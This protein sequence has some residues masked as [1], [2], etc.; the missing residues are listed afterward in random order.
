MRH[1]VAPLVIAALLSLCSWQLLERRAVVTLDLESGKRNIVKLYWSTDDAPYGE[2]RMTTLVVGPGV[3]THQCRIGDLATIRRLRIDP[4]ER[5]HDWV[6]LKRLTLRQ[7]GFSEQQL[8]GTEELSRLVPL[9]GLAELES[10]EEGLWL[11][12]EGHD[13]RLEWRLPPMERH[14]GL[15]G[16][17]VRTACIFAAVLL[18]ARVT[19][20]TELGRHGWVP[21][22]LS[23]TLV[24]VSAMALLS[25]ENAHPDEAVHVEAARYF[26]HHWLP[27][28]IDDP[29]LRHTFSHYGFSRVFS[30]EIY[31]WVAGRYLQLVEPLQLPSYLAL[32]GLNVLLWAVMVLGVLAVPPARPLGVPLLI[33]PQICYVFS[34]CNS[35]A[36]ALT[37]SMIVAWQIAVPG[38]MFSRF[39]AGEDAGYWRR[40]L[41]LGSL[42]GLL[43]LAKKNYYFFLLF[44]PCFLA[45]VS[46]RQ[47]LVPWR[48]LWQRGLALAAVGALLFGL[49]RGSE[50]A[51]NGWD[52]SAKLYRAR[53]ETASPL[54]NP[55]SPRAAQHPHLG[56][57]D[58]GVGLQVL[59]DK[60]RW[61]EKTF[62][63]SFGVYGYTSVSASFAYY[64]L[65]RYLGLGLLGLLV[66]SVLLRGGWPGIIQ[67][68]LAGLV[69]GGL[70]TAALYI[71]WTHDFQA[72]GRY[73]L[74]LVPV[75]AMMYVRL[76]PVLPVALFQTLV[77][78]LYCVSLYSFVFVAIPGIL[79]RYGI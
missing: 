29:A 51:V 22:L 44:I 17:L 52:R 7:V 74:P 32:R 35:D 48:R 64:D 47:D 71:A 37:V 45:G 46:F 60:E 75:L 68:G 39:F 76:Y 13:A 42:V 18:L 28:E 50:Y 66:L 72:Q 59:L 40:C 3:S 53:V 23:M 9:G 27:P 69:A 12:S 41:L 11:A 61:G 78:L 62:R 77:L 2:E 65:V 26:Q 31:Y 63:S 58:R 43:L 54:F 73:L 36:M 49:V 25:Q 1:M 8:A 34:Y 6:M 4:T 20:G 14:G 19:H 57:R 16:T 15:P 56:M 67:L 70:G 30:G 5:H 33:S 38:T 79:L 24:L 10:R 21:Y 55:E